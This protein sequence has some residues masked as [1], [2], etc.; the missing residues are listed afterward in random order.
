[1]SPEQLIELVRK[2]ATAA[3]PFA[4]LLVLQ[5]EAEIDRNGAQHF[6]DCTI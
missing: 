4:Q 5:A 1:M 6:S 3:E 2:I